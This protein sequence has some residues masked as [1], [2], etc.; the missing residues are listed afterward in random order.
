MSL[1][2]WSI[3]MDAQRV[4]ERRAMRGFV[5][6]AKVWSAMYESSAKGEVNS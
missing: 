3:W 6:A 4:L 2:K 5:P 1:D